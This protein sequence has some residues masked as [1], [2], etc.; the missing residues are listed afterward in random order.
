MILLM[1]TLNEQ[2]SWVVRISNKVK[3]QNHFKKNTALF[4]NFYKNI[5]IVWIN[6]YKSFEI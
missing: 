2:V 5:I 4:G 6:D 3:S 1:D